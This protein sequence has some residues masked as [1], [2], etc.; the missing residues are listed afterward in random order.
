MFTIPF[1]D[2]FDDDEGNNNFE[3]YGGIMSYYS[4]ASTQRGTPQSV[5]SDLSEFSPGT[6]RKRRESNAFRIRIKSY[7]KHFRTGS[8][9]GGFDENVDQNVLSSMKKRSSKKR[10][11][12]L[13]GGSGSRFRA[14]VVGKAKSLWR[15][16]WSTKEFRTPS[17]QKRRR[18]ISSTPELEMIQEGNDLT[19]RRIHRRGECVSALYYA[20]ILGLLGPNSFYMFLRRRGRR[21]CGPSPPL[22]PPPPSSSKGTASTTTPRT[23]KRRNS[24]SLRPRRRR[25][26]DLASPAASTMR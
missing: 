15:Q 1:Q 9:T 21:M 8:W 25:S 6:S 23:K 4:P 10:S 18:R 24:S 20:L 14:Q 19:F 2:M 3:S 12:K 17:P 16:L 22:M 26:L 5:S 11:E 7:I 13:D